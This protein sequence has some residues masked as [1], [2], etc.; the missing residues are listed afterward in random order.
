MQTGVPSPRTPQQPVGQLSAV[1]AQAPFTQAAPPG[2]ATQ[3]APPVPH[4]CA[5]G[6]LTQVA[7]WQQP[8]G[9]VAALQL[10]HWPLRQIVPL[11]QVMQSAPLTP[12]A[13]VEVPGWQAEPAQQP[14][15]SPGP[16]VDW[17]KPFTQVPSEVA[18]STQV[19]PPR[20]QASSLD[21]KQAPPG[22]QQPFGQVSGP[23]GRHSPS[24]QARPVPHC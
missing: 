17:Q 12:Q 1:Q 8:V 11:G 3:L 24:K 23:Q 14:A 16:Q 5:V 6:G 9:Q 10:W 22:S 20:P 7:P 2:Q 13:A 4:N 21:T 18:Q 19:A 15:Q